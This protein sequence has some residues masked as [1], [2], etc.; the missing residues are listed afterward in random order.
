MAKT[1]ELGI[2]DHDGVIVDSFK[3]LHESYEP[4]CSRFGVAYPSSERLKQLYMEHPKYTDLL[5][6]LGIAPEH[7]KEADE[8]FAE[9]MNQKHREPAVFPGIE[10]VL[11]KL[12]K[13][14]SLA[15]VSSNHKPIVIPLL[16]KHNLLRYFDKV[17]TNECMGTY[18]EKTPAMDE[19]MWSFRA[20]GEQTFAIG[21][22]TADYIHA[23]EAGISADNVIM[24]E[25]GWGYERDKLPGY[26]LK[27]VVKTPIDILEAVKEIESS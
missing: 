21:D 4:I 20:S 22:R 19:I 15:L 25:Y 2:F 8:I 18:F 5:T 7:H 14:M 16:S 13:C 12:S 24:V 11:E 10:E 17:I 27:T 6:C 9:A 1:L 23:R 3:C 26:N